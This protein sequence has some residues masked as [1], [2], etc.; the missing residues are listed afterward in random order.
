LPGGF[1]SD[2]KSQ[3]GKILE[4]PRLENVDIFYVHLGYFSE[5]WDILLPFGT[6]FVNLVHF[7]GFGIMHQEKS[8]NPE[9]RHLYL[10]ATLRCAVAAAVAFDSP[11]YHFFGGKIYFFVGGR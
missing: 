8:G 10:F 4:G 6:F 11:F 5:I 2:Q 1:F 9:E 7:S 3:F